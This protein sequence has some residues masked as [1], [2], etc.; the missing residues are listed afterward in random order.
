MGAQNTKRNK[1]SFNETGWRGR[2]GLRKIGNLVIDSDPDR[3]ALLCLLLQLEVD[4]SNVSLLDAQGLFSTIING[5][6]VGKQ[7][8]NLRDL[9]M[10]RPVLW[11]LG[12]LDVAWAPA[13]KPII[14][15]VLCGTTKSGRVQALL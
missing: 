4:C 1:T 9:C 15:Q 11:R 10:G 5:E 2:A 12:Y 6:A 3:G 7:V 14:H 8:G 13:G